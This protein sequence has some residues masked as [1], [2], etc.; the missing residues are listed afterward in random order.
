MNVEG[1]V[2]ANDRRDDERDDWVEQERDADLIDIRALLGTLWRRKWVVV[3]TVLFCIG[4]A[5]AVLQQITPK[6]TATALVMLNTRETK[7]VDIES[8]LSGL[9]ANTD[10][11]DG[12]IA[13][14]LLYTS[15]SPRDRS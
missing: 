4:L 8:V 14:C 7:V 11:A 15:P 5:V 13:V 9:P 3:L 12:E 6:Y 1:R 2:R 10:A